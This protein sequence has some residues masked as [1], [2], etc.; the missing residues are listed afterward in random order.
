VSRVKTVVAT[1]VLLVV[2]LL[3]FVGVAF[4]AQ[5][6]LGLSD[7]VR[8]GVPLALLLSAVPAFL[9]LGYFYLQDRH[10]PEPKH[11]VA[12]VYLAGGF[13]AA[14]VAS[15]VMESLLPAQESALALNLTWTRVLHAILVVGLAQEFAKFLIVRYSIYLSDE[16]DEP[17]DGIIYMTAAGIGF[18]TAE[19]IRYFHGVGGVFLG[20]GAGNAVITTMAHACFA[21][22]LGYALGRAKFSDFSPLRRNLTLVS[23]L[24][25]AST[26]NG[27]FDLL[28]ERVTNAGMTAQPWRGL[29][30]ASGFAVVVFIFTSL[31][32]RRH[33]AVSPHASAS[34]PATTGAAS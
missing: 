27:L 25:V 24:L 5:K 1:E 32:M 26:L 4:G 20:I 2:G 28:E 34:M 14:P 30:F 13:V 11:Y 22:V 21:G 15:F 29:A 17:M 8:V 23:G 33:L 31:M 3:A 10:E 19:N 7:P 12:G 18:A 6:I 16:F 9:W